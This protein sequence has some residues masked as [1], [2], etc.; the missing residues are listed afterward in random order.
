MIGKRCHWL[1]WDTFWSSV[2]RESVLLLVRLL[3]FLLGRQKVGGT[4]KPDYRAIGTLEPDYS[5]LKIRSSGYKF[6][7][8]YV[9]ERK[10]IECGRR[11]QFLS[12]IGPDPL[13]GPG[14]SCCVTDLV[15]VLVYKFDPL[16]LYFG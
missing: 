10:V 2:Q 12:G 15:I 1:N 11:I 3:N 9:G 4:V 16:G 5:V 6:T 8:F 14:W 7:R 13:L